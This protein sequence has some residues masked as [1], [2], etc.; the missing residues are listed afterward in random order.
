MVLFLNC[1]VSSFGEAEIGK[2]E[3]LNCEKNKSNCFIGIKKF[4]KTGDNLQ[5]LGSAY[6]QLL[7]SSKKKTLLDK[8]DQT[9][10]LDQSAVKIPLLFIEIP[11]NADLRT[12]PLIKIDGKNILNTE[13]LFCND[14]SGC[15]TAVGIDKET[16]NLFKKGN[17]LSVAFKIYGTSQ[18]NFNIDFSLKN[19]TKSYAALVKL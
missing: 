1:S 9:N 17:T 15:R 8:E 6:I 5:V 2:W 18:K 10:K 12:K 13:F 3:L 16:I 11:L 7:A 19:F 14:K 4:I